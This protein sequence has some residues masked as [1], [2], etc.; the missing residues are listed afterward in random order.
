MGDPPRRA[1]RQ[2]VVAGLWCRN[3]LSGE[4]IKCHTR[5]IDASGHDRLVFK[6]QQ[7]TTAKLGFAD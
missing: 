7:R 5:A 2:Q 6:Q 1:P 4:R 3:V